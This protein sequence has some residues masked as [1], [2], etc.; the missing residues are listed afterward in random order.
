MNCDSTLPTRTTFKF[1]LFFHDGCWPTDKELW[2]RCVAIIFR[3]RYLR[4]AWPWLSYHIVIHDEK[5]IEGDPIL[6]SVVILSS[7]ATVALHFRAILV[8]Y[9]FDWFKT[10]VI[11]QVQATRVHTPTFVCG[12]GTRAPSE[13]TSCMRLLQHYHIVAWRVFSIAAL[14][15][16]PNALLSIRGHIA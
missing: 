5:I 4:F 6:R 8:Q 15:S 1:G 13:L 3:Y 2:R 11:V 10:G 9:A 16:K 14:W 7:L 12:S